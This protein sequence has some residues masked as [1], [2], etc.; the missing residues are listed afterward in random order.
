MESTSI[1][2]VGAFF[3]IL[4]FLTWGFFPGPADAAENAFD[5]QTILSLEINSKAQMTI[6]T[7]TRQTGI[8]TGI[9][10]S[11]R[12]IRQSLDSLYATGLFT[13][14]VVEAQSIDGGVAVV[15]NLI[16][17]AVLA[18]LQIKGNRVFWDRTLMGA[19]NLAIGGEFTEPRWKSAIDSLLNFLHRKGYFRPKVKTEVTELPG[20]NQVRVT[21]RV[22]EGIRARVL[23]TR[24]TGN[25]VTSN[26]RLWS[27]VRLKG[28]EFYDAD[29]LDQDLHRLEALYKENGFVR[30]VIGP[31]ELI[32]HES[33]HEVEIRIPIEAEKR[34][35]VLFEGNDPYPAGRLEPLLLFSEERSYDEAVFRASADQVAEFYRSNGYPFAKVDFTREDGPEGGELLA[36]FKVH[37]GKFACLR[38]I[39]FIGNSFYPDSR[40]LQFIRTHPGNTMFCGI[41]NGE[42]LESD[43]KTLKTRYLEQGFGQV[44]VEARIEYNE[45][46]SLAH[47]VYSLSEGPRT[48][49]A[50]IQFDGNSVL[51][52]DEFRKVTRLRPGQPYDTVP[53]RKDTEEMLV[54]YHQHGHIYAE[55]DSELKFSE[56]RR[57]VS[58]RYR[59]RE[60]EQ[61]RIGRILLGG[62][63][64]TRDSVILREVLVGPG[65]PYDETR[66]LLSR[67]RVQQLGYVG[68]VRFE[69]INPINPESR[70]LVKDMR[71]TVQERP[72]KTLDLGI[73]YGDVERLRGFIEG[74]HRNLMG[75]GRSLSLRAEGSQIESKYSVTYREPWVFG[76]RMDGRLVA[77]DQSQVRDTYELVTVGGT[78]GLEKE[79]TPRIKAGV[80]YQFEHNRFTETVPESELLSEDKRA[81][82]ASLNPSL[83]WDTRNDPFNPTA[84]FL[85]GITFRDAALLLGSQVQFTK[86]TIRTSWYVPITRWMV[87]A[88]SA[89]GGMADRFGKTQTE[90]IFGE[91]ELVPPSER[92][93]LGG[94]STVRGYPQDQLGIVGR[95]MVPKTDGSGVEFIGGN[96]MVLVNGEIRLFLPGGV[97]LVFFH[98]RGNVYRRYEEVDFSLLKSTVGAGLWV[99]TPVGPL[100]LDYGYKLNREKDLCIVPTSDPERPYTI[101]K[102][103]VGCTNPVEESKAELHFTLGFAF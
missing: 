54:L 4:P 66:I 14:V 81:N 72:T 24:F 3:L 48:L 50:E 71:L 23:A 103:P 86:T 41:V 44:Q 47:L 99:G 77:F 100:R 52:A 1:R 96:A 37:S 33:T 43:V 29:I 25:P 8:H 59:I 65:D 42:D 75:T 58:I 7:L 6:E 73:G 45:E 49:V 15:Y 40:L 84:G 32:D 30:S 92:F 64:T 2:R 98:D 70:E 76:Y 61:A 17:K 21:V 28:G 55:I 80:Q 79:L 51:G 87:F 9:P 82:I 10:Y 35:R 22:N 5:G 91:T 53:V 46:K 74:T 11:T 19:M 102:V 68:G 12:A 13:D 18:D 93:F 62:N 101:E 89:R 31:P 67:R 20:T 39:T 34:L 36:V 69:P 85:H 16:D 60:N 27:A 90:P 26:F 88:L 83:I 97:G 38:T 95:T 63:T 78:A 56:D 94:R 57:E